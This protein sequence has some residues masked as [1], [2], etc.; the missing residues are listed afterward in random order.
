MYHSQLNQE[1][2]HWACKCRTPAWTRRTHGTFFQRL[3]CKKVVNWHYH[4]VLCGLFSDPRLLLG[5]EAFIMF[6]T[7]L[8]VS[9]CL[10]P[11]GLSNLFH[12]FWQLQYSKK[13]QL[14]KGD[15]QDLVAMS[16]YKS[17]LTRH[18]EWGWSIEGEMTPW[19]HMRY[20]PHSFHICHTPQNSWR[21]L[22]WHCPN[23]RNL[24]KFSTSKV[25]LYMSLPDHAKNPSTALALCER[26]CSLHSAFNTADMVIMWP[27][28]V[29]QQTIK[30]VAAHVLLYVCISGQSSIYDDYYLLFHTCKYFNNYWT[31]PKSPE[32]Y[33]TN[34]PKVNSGRIEFVVSPSNIECDF[35][36]L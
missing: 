22:S 29:I 19:V 8:S 4:T 12:L 1:N 23:P 35:S 33:N 16:L 13:E 14:L 20:V 25:S 27:T 9:G 34:C 3:I 7:W 21:K 17:T 24:R 2:E 31:P 36:S 11:S 18:V 30:C 10:P 5:S 15:H 6:H 28:W 32:L 26:K